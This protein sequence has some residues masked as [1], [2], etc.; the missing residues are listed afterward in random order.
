MGTPDA[1]P[2][3]RKIFATTR[4]S[5]ILRAKEGGEIGAA[6]LESLCRAYW[7]PLRGYLLRSGYSPADA[8]DYAQEFFS[9]LLRRGSFSKVVRER[10]RFRN[11]L[12]VSLRHFLADERDKALAA[13]RGGGATVVSLDLADQEGFPEFEISDQFTPDQIFE[14][15]W[16][17]TVLA[18][19]REKLRRECV[20]NHKQEVY[21]ALGPEGNDTE[22]TYAQIGARLGLSEEG[23]KSAAFR[24]R[25]RYRELIRTEVAETVESEAELEEEL[26]HLLRVLEN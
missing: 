22:E 10:G 20:A 8:E 23:V 18:H 21:A 6:A 4:W 17:E 11:F 2:P 7:R 16:A 25:R 13:R 12:L 15:H 24:L 9:R 1:L 26:R 5:L 14:R 3:D 19:A